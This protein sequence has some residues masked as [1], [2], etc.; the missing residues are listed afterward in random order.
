VT[1]ARSAPSRGGPS[2]TGTYFRAAGSRSSLVSGCAWD[3]QPSTRRV[4]HV[5]RAPGPA[6]GSEIHSTAL[7]A[8]REAVAV[9]NAVPTDVRSRPRLQQVARRARAGPRPRIRPGSGPPRRGAASRLRWRPVVSVR[10]PP[11]GTAPQDA[12][13]HVGSSVIRGRDGRRGRDRVDRPWCVPRGTTRPGRQQRGTPPCS[14]TRRGVFHV[15]TTR[16]APSR[17]GPSLACRRVPRGTGR[18]QNTGRFAGIPGF[19]GYRGGHGSTCSSAWY[20]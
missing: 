14:G 3:S 7:P 18:V 10:R 11:T 13:S 20:R 5:E 17:P 16:P 4:F 2:A 19:R 6:A 12:T 9:G 15:G 1:A 8:R